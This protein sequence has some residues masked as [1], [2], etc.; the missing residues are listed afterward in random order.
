MAKSL[1]S[2]DIEDLAADIGKDVYIDV[3]KW[4]LYLNDAHLHTT[5]AE[6]FAPLI[7]ADDVSEATIK[8]VLQSI[9]VKIG[10]G[11]QELPLIDFLPVQCQVSLMDI[12]EEYL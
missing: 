6:K 3:A 4:H 1:T 9:S 11:N 5:L 8:T 7:E 2:R 12:L 10:G